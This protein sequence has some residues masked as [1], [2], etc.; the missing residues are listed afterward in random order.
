MSESHLSVT[1]IAAGAVRSFQSALVR[2]MFI[3][4]GIVPAF[5][6]D[7]VKDLVRVAPVRATL[8]R[9]NLLSQIIYS[10]IHKMKDS[11]DLR[12]NG[13]GSEGEVRPTKSP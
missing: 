8:V 5:L 1:F 3:R 10:L 4:A 9:A 2:A 7:L 6:R 11:L 12:F 13:G